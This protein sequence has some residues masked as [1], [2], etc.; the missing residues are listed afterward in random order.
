MLVNTVEYIRLLVLDTHGRASLNHQ[1]IITDIT[2]SDPRLASIS[3]VD[4]YEKRMIQIYNATGTVFLN[5]VSTKYNAEMMNNAGQKSGYF[6]RA[7]QLKDGLYVNHNVQ[8]S[9]RIEVVE[10][11]D[12]QPRFKSIY[13]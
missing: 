5:S 12:I 2:S 4:D 6:G 8:D 1:S 7:P 13:F 10:N 9:M 3:K 11:V